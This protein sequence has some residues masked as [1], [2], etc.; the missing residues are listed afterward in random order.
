MWFLDLGFP[1]SWRDYTLEPQNCVDIR[2][3]TPGSRRRV[4]SSRGHTESE[5]FLFF[6]S[7]FIGAITLGR[8]WLH[9]GIN[10]HFAQHRLWLPDAHTAA[11]AVFWL[12]ETD[13]GPE[14]DT[15]SAPSFRSA[16]VLSLRFG[17]QRAPVLSGKLSCVCRK[18]CVTFY[19]QIL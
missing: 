2:S 13:T 15:T 3:G 19:P 16:S 4:I 5:N 11:E 7:L 17:S 1:G 9:D 12:V 18:I 6:S 14:P 10:S 8:S